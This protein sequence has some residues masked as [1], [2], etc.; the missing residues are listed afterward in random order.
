[1]IGVVIAGGFGATMDH[2]RI[3]GV[4][5][6]VSASEGRKNSDHEGAGR[7]DGGCDSASAGAGGGRKISSC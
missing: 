3:H 2:R 4:T 6:D 5:S 1:M 7:L